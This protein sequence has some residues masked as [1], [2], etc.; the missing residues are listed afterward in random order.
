MDKK[1][2]IWLWIPLLV[3]I[4]P[5]IF[6]SP[7]G[8]FF[9]SIL[10]PTIDGTIQIWRNNFLTNPKFD[11]LFIPT[12]LIQFVGI[13]I[14]TFNWIRFKKSFKSR[15]LYWSIL[16]IAT[17]LSLISLFVLVIGYSISNISFP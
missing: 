8:N 2:K 16:I 12:L 5:E 10:S 6:L 9:Y 14:F 13:I 11:F 17:L 3:F 1:Q 15:S 7:I 4:L